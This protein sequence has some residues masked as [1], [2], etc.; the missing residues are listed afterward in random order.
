MASFGQW[1]VAAEGRF[2]SARALAAVESVVGVANADEVAALAMGEA[3]DKCRE[4]ANERYKSLVGGGMLRG[5]ALKVIYEE[6][7]S[8][9]S[10]LALAPSCAPSSQ[11]LATL[12]KRGA[13]ALAKK[14]AAAPTVGGAKVGA[15]RKRAETKRKGRE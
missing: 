7:S 11:A 10:K 4:E 12:P 15:T 5:A 13:K 14:P 3:F 6:S 2:A 9:F 1:R 8:E